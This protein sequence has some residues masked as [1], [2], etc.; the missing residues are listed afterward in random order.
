LNWHTNGQVEWEA[1]FKAC[2]MVGLPSAADGRDRDQ[3]VFYT[4]ETARAGPGLLGNNQL[5]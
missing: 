5:F 3:V 4:V 1:I 2:G